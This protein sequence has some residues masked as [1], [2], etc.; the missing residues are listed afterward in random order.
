ML[1]KHTSLATRVLHLTSFKHLKE[2]LNK[3]GH[4][5]YDEMHAVSSRTAKEVLTQKEAFGT[6][7]PTN[8][9][10][11]AFVQ[12]GADN[13]DLNEETLD[14]KNTTHATKMVIYQN[15]MFGPDPSP[16]Q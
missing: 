1:P 7:I 2:L 6:V 14:D 8:I 12:I 5:S 15:K 11:G 9:K 13:N 10:P 3:I 16:P 4:V